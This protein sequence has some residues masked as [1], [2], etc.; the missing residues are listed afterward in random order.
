MKDTDYLTISARV[1]V[2]ETRLLTA[3]RRERMI[4]ARTPDEALKVLTE[5]GYPEPESAAL[6][7]VDRALTRG[8][9]ALFDELKKAVPEPGLVEVFQIKYDTHNAKVLL[10][11]AAMG[12][13]PARLLM[14]GG[15]YDPHT[16]AQALADR[17]TEKLSPV[18][19]D[20]Y[21]QAKAVLADTGDPQ[22]ADLILDAA[23]Y[24]EMSIAAQKTGSGF[25]KGYVR[26]SVDA[27]NLRS[28][29]RCL[30]AGAD[31]ELKKAAL[32][33][34]GDLPA[35]ALLE[36]KGEDLPAKYK[37]T[38]LEK[39]ALLGAETARPG[40]GS[41]TEVERACDN[42]LV[43]YLAQARRIPFGEQPVVG[44]LCAREAEAT[45]VRTILALRSAGLAGDAIRERL[46]ESYV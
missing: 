23:C 33:P 13:D 18:F 34:G 45:T 16:L 30:R 22:R 12:E 29:V 36:I 5:C 39:A 8:R 37:N 38:P 9:L 46:G 6:P 17:D 25:L 1:R 28:L 7:A 10:K 43:G 44:Y 41:L 11:A 27:A 26:L 24:A 3:E 2:W 4:D 32:L 20:A 31:Q 21:E 35:A 14:E 19:L 42:A 40:E 15:R